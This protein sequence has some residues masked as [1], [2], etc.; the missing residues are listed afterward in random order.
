MRRVH[1]PLPDHRAA[2]LGAHHDHVPAR[3]W[4][5]ETKSVKL[6]L[7]TFREEG[8]F[9]EHLATVIRDDFVAALAPVELSVTV[10]FNAR[11]GIALRAVSSYL[12]NWCQ[13]PIIHPYSYRPLVQVSRTT[14][15]LSRGSAGASRSQIQMASSS[16][17]GFSRPGD[18]VQVAVVEP[19]AERLRTPP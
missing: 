16:L 15:W 8:I 4:A 2:R 17:V 5:V 3:R 18:L 14:T 6:Y 10:N 11:G 19:V 9:H 1:L 12:N 7:E 13:A